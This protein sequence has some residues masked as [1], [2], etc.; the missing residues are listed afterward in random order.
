MAVLDGVRVGPLDPDRGETFGM[1]AGGPT[2]RQL[3]RHHM[4]INPPALLAAIGRKRHQER[5]EAIDRDEAEKAILK[6]YKDAGEELPEDAELSGFAVRGEEDK[7]DQQVVSFT[8]TLPSGRSGK[9]FVP[10]RG[11]SKSVKAGDEAVRVS[12]LKEAGLPW[13]AEAT[14]Q[15][16][17]KAGEQERR[18]AER[19]R[20]ENEELKAKLASFEEQRPSVHEQGGQAPAGSDAEQE[21]GEPFEGYDEKNAKDIAKQVRESGDAQLAQRVRDYEKSGQNRKSV[22]GAADAVLDRK[23]S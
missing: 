21:Q 18:D 16:E 4:A 8:Y 19:L 12:K 2:A 23:P 6:H 7:P 9:G 10:Y 3:V 15:A 13:Q 22:V 20:E 5:S 14:A 17:S 1:A 11:L